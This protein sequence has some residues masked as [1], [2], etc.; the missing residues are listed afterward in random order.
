M[1]QGLIPADGEIWRTRRRA[2]LPSLHKKYIDAMVG[3]FGDCAELGSRTL[4]VAFSPKDSERIEAIVADG[5]TR[6]RQLGGSGAMQAERL[7]QEAK[8]R[9]ER[10][11]ADRNRIGTRRTRRGRDCRDGQLRQPRGARRKYADQP[12]VRSAAR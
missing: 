6:V 1:G 5:G 4:D 3:M 9:L 12:R 2:I 10:S 8:G 11:V 7:E